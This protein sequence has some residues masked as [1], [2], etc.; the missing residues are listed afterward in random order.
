MFVAKFLQTK[1]KCVAGVQNKKK[2]VAGVQNEKKSVAGVQESK[3][4]QRAT[5]D[6]VKKNWLNFGGDRFGQN[7][8]IPVHKKL[9]TDTCVS[10]LMRIKR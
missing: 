1:K 10:L 8:P 6:S 2:S 5:Q 4:V 9:K 7:W 3:I